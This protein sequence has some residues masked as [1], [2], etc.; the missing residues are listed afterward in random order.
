LSLALIAAL[1]GAPVVLSAEM[2]TKPYQGS[3]EFERMKT[4]VGSWEATMPMPDGE[5]AEMSEKHKEMSGEQKKMMQKMRVS[6]R[7]TAGGSALLETTAAGTPM[8]MIS[9]YHDRGG[10]L[11]M[12]HYCML[13]NQPQMVL[14]SSDEDKI[15]FQFADTNRL[16]ANKEMHMHS[17]VLSFVD[18]DHMVQ[19]WTMF[20]D[21][22]AGHAQ[23]MKFTRKE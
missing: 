2:D 7:L 5:S 21:G 15:S 17:M 19:R 13:G 11:F 10:K 20:Q 3:A 1:V 12:T 18:K 14:E 8:E 16:D 23:D 9:M 6:Y 4:L 22:A